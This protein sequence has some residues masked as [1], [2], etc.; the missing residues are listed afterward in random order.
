MK[1][2]SIIALLASAIIFFAVDPILSQ[3]AADPGPTHFALEIIARSDLPATY[4]PV[5]GL[6]AAF[7]GAW[8]FRFG[9]V[10]SWR[11]T[12]GAL[13]VRS[14]RVMSKLGESMRPGNQGCTED[15]TAATFY[16]LR[17]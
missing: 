3:R 10:S 4:Q 7:E 8:F 6:D 15:L 16:W 1:R 12:A 5:P 9:R 2:V 13:P 14:V 11:P 17:K